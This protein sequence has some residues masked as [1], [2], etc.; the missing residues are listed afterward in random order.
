MKGIS[1]QQKT[2]QNKRLPITAAILNRLYAV[3]DGKLFDTYK[4]V[5]V[6]A[7]CSLAYFGFLR[8]G[9][10]TTYCNVFDPEANLCLGDL[11]FEFKSNKPVSMNLFLKASKTDPMRQGCTIRYFAVKGVI[12]PV[13]SLH[14]FLQL[15]LLLN[16]DPQSPLFILPDGA[17]LSRS[18]FLSMLNTA[19]RQ[20]GIPPEGYSGHSFRIGAATACAKH[21]VP[22]HLIQTMGRWSSS[23]YKT[24]IK[25]SH[26][27]IREAQGS[28][29]N[30]D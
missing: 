20:A 13:E 25:V 14:K 16:R 24:Y 29:A 1:K 17:P 4:D 9:E 7:A 15:R 10:F 8:C 21:H 11:T 19:C 5:L 6:K 26:S 23:C 2:K 12:C 28:M 22:E 27:L 18:L 30:D 3:L